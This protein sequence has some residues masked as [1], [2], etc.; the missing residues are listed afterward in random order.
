MTDVSYVT[1]A[2][3]RVLVG[4]RKRMALGAKLSLKGV[5]PFVRHVLELSK[6]T[7]L[8]GQ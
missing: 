8:I 5:Q 7:S 1:S 4:L 3:I 2:G 6:L